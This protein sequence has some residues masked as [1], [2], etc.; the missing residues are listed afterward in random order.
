MEPKLY[1]YRAWMQS[2]TEYIQQRHFIKI[3]MFKIPL[4]RHQPKQVC[5]YSAHT[6]QHSTVV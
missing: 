6:V 2:F 1:A 5:V 3:S 4:F